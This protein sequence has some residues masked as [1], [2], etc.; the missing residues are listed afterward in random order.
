MARVLP[1]YPVPDS[2][3]PEQTALFNAYVSRLLSGVEQTWWDAIGSEFYK[4]Y[5]GQL[6]ISMFE[7]SNN[8]Y[9]L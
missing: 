9:P 6:C 5:F 2:Y 7:E 4:E 1:L 8:V 3:N